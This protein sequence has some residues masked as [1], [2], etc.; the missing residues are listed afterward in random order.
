MQ[1]LQTTGNCIHLLPV[2]GSHD[3]PWNL[4]R[5][6]IFCHKNTHRS[7]NAMQK[8]MSIR[9]PWPQ[10]NVSECLV[11]CLPRKWLNYIF[12]IGCFFGFL[13]NGTLGPQPLKT[14]GFYGQNF[15]R[16]TTLGPFASRN[17]MESSEW[18]VHPPSAATTEGVFPQL[19]SSLFCFF[20]VWVSDVDS[21]GSS[22]GLKFEPLNHQKQT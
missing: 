8:E 18:R 3:V 9:D 12:S 4:F 13:R 16:E 10:V 7:N 14:T 20:L 1:N 19:T 2:L 21:P 5:F 22:K 15:W 17:P 11:L 6:H